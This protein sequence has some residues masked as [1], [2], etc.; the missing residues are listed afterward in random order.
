MTNR[1]KLWLFLYFNKKNKKNVIK[2]S[3]APKLSDLRIG[4]NSNN[5][6]ELVKSENSK[7]LI[8]SRFD[9]PLEN[10]KEEK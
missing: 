4:E 6:S 3:W 1:K 2:L 8:I 10:I 9:K 7:N 5:I